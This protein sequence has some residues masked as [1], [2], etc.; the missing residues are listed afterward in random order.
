M[1][2]VLKE[3]AIHA[4]IDSTALLE[5]HTHGLEKYGH[6]NFSVMAPAIYRASACR[7]LNYLADAVLN[8]GEI[9]KAGE[10][11]EGGEWD[12]FTIEE[13]SDSNELPVLRIIP[14]MPECD[15]RRD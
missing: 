4:I 3:I 8:K 6:I 13:G 11:C 10:N 14:I 5:V 7:L 12:R 9:F 2:D 1:V 15:A